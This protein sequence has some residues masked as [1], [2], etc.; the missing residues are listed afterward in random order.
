M[1]AHV[2]LRTYT[3]FFAPLSTCIPLTL[4]FLRHPGAIMLLYHHPAILTALNVHTI[5]A[6]V[7]GLCTYVTRFIKRS[8]RSLDIA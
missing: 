4:G 1:Q 2:L 3:S 6:L 8:Q 5:T 7:A